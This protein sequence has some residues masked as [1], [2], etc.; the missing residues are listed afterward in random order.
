MNR[1]REII[2]DLQPNLTGEQYD[3]IDVLLWKERQLKQLQDAI[4]A[5]DV[6]DAWFEHDPAYDEYM[7]VHCCS[8][9]VH[10]SSCPVTKLRQVLKEQGVSDET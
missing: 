4:M 9:E 5:L 3:A 10:D 6:E 1:N 8:R 2:R 7:C